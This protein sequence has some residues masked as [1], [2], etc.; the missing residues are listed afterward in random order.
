MLFSSWKPG[1]L[2]IKPFLLLKPTVGW[3][4]R[5]HFNLGNPGI[6]HCNGAFLAFPL[7]ILWWNRN[8][9]VGSGN[10]KKMGCYTKRFL[11]LPH[12]VFHGLNNNSAGVF[13]PEAPVLFLVE[14][15]IVVV[16]LLKIGTIRVQV[17]PF[18]VVENIGIVNGV[19]CTGPVG[20]A[21]S[22]CTFLLHQV[23]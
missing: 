1:R 2:L 4:N 16:V 11:E 23:A 13:C 3:Q 15:V 18:G 14:A 6:I 22:G 8:Q 9:F 5:I 17:K 21:I 12:C 20:T 10:I 19:L 7:V